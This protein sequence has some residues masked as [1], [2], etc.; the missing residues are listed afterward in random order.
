MH[1]LS[2]W[3]DTPA[4]KAKS[5]PA[6]VKGDTRFVYPASAFAAFLDFLPTVRLKIWDIAL[7]CTLY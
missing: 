2:C 6:A 5:I 3:N 7:E 1:R 4:F